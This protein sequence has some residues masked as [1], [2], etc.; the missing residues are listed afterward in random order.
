VPLVLDAPL[1][2]AAA[3]GPV[4]AVDGIAT[5]DAATSGVSVFLVNRSPAEPV[6]LDL[7]LDGP[8]AMRAIE[9]LVLADGDPSARNTTE[10]PTRVAPRH[11]PPPADVDGRH[12]VTLPPV[13]W[14]MLRFELATQ[15]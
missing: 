13:S 12:L 2:D 7:A 11:E 15:P 1:I 3:H 9:H 5:Y 4:P 6:A 10:T 14:S 8:G